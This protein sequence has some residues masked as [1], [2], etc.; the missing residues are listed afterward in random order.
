VPAAAGRVVGID[1]ARCLALV[2]MMA[3]HILPSTVDGE[4]SLAHQ[5]AGGRASALFA[6]LA[7]TSLVLVA[8]TRQPMRGRSLGGMIAGTAVRAAFIGFVGLLLGDLRSGIAVILAYYAVLF[9]VAVP[10]LAL[11]TRW[12]VVVAL[13]WAVLGPLVSHLWRERLPLTSYAV[14][15]PASL[16][17]PVTLVRDL[18]LTGYY[19]VLTWVP[20]VLLGMAVGRI[21]L[22]SWRTTW[23]LGAAG[24]WAVLVSWSV[25]DAI[26]ARTGVRAELIETFSGAGWRGDLD[27]TLVDGLYGVTPTGSLW[28]LA[29]RAPHSGT[30]FDLLMTGGSAC[31]VIALCLALGRLAPRTLSVLFG[32]GAMTL[33]LYTLHVALRTDGLWDGDDTAT[34]VGQVVLVL[35]VGA[36]F[37]LLR[38]RGPLEAVVGEVS[39]GVRGAVA[40]RAPGTG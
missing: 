32:A 30:T 11:R 20:Y 16:A 33:T 23:L 19:P 39:Q 40:G 9:V 7:G 37:R 18:V 6:V 21:D 36:G 10:F 25:S 24:A 34:F 15:S 31:L 8:G 5:V 26:L 17:E 2:G 28:W 13:V 22:R 35:V 1:V 12:L 38:Q 4:V 29:V 27:T 14:P 3:T